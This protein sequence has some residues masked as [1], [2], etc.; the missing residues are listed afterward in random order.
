MLETRDLRLLRAIASNGSLVRAARELGVSQPALTRSLAA[1]EAKLRGPVFERSRKGV[2]PTNLGRVLL[3]EADEIL[4]RLERLE[5]TATEA[6]GGS[7]RELRIAAGNYVTEAV[8]GRAAARMLAVQPC[9][10]VRLIPGDWADVPRLLNAREA[11]LGLLD[12]GGFD[13]ESGLEAKALPPLPG[14]FLAR[15]GHPLSRLD[16]PTL[17]DIL[18]WPVILIGRVTQTLQGPMVTARETARL[19]AH[20]HAAFPAMVNES[21]AAAVNLLAYC[22]AVLPLTLPNA[23]AALRSGEVVP[24]RWREPWLC[25]HPGVVRLRNRPLGEAERAFLDL[26]QDAT[27][28]AEAESRAFLQDLGLSAEC[29]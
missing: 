4:L 28:M 16:A 9:T 13:R 3:A 24:I 21:P 15:R 14:F 6:N 29:L 7:T 27:S 12:L 23:G 1:L 18:A 25:L 17:A 10:R 8:G 26:L 11:S 22:D 2:I 20:A 5:R 19:A